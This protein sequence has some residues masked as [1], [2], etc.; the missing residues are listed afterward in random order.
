MFEEIRENERK[1]SK[2]EGKIRWKGEEE[3]SEV[4]KEGGNKRRWNGKEKRRGREVKRE[5]M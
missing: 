2:E 1:R 3:T 4:S 5:G